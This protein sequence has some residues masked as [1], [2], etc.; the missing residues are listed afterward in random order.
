MI[1]IGGTIELIF[2]ERN[3]RSEPY[4]NAVVPSPGH[5]N[6][7]VCWFAGDPLKARMP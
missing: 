4:K 7:P 1:S 3:N 5:R 6:D 2:I